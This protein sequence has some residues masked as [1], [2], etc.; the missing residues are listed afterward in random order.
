MIHRFGFSVSPLLSLTPLGLRGARAVAT[1]CIALD[2]LE[3]RRVL[4]ENSPLY[5]VT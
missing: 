5:S 3:H 2:I 1:L 4:E